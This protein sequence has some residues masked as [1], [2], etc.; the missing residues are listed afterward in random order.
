MRYYLAS[1][2]STGRQYELTTYGR[3]RMPVLHWPSGQ[4]HW[5]TRDAAANFLRRARRNGD[6]RL[7][8]FGG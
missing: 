8:R 1:H 6:Y 4:R 2:I 3:D 5:I 7:E